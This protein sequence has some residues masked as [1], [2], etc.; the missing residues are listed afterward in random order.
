MIALLVVFASQV[1]FA[2]VPL[3]QLVNHS[4]WIV[5]A[6]RD[7]D[8]W[9]VIE[10]IHWKAGDK[11]PAGSIKVLDAGQDLREMMAK[12]FAEHGNQ[13]MP[14]PIVESYASSIDQAKFAKTKRAIL[15]LRR[16]KSDWQFALEGGYEAVVKKSAVLDAL[17]P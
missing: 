7:K 6:E 5:I 17:K 10:T 15:F 12:H 9:K 13:G 2:P 11:Q 3:K 16:W 1:H 8:R 14:S 4:Q